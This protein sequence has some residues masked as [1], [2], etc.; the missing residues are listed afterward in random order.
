MPYLAVNLALSFSVIRL[1]TSG[2]GRR[3]AYEFILQAF[4]HR[5]AFDRI[6]LEMHHT[7]D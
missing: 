2:G 1:Y 4:D 6:D 7:K 3:A 5:S